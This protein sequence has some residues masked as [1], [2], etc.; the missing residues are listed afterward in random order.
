MKNKP[1][2]FVYCLLCPWVKHLTGRLRL[3]VED[4]LPGL[5][6]EW[7]P[8][9]VLAQDSLHDEHNQAKY[10]FLGLKKFRESSFFVVKL[11]LM[12]H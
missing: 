10:N 11:I 12:L 2:N 4:R 1:A 7:A 3:Y 5:E 9:G 8:P 6:R